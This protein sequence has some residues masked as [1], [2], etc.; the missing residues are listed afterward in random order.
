M[1]RFWQISLPLCS[2]GSALSPLWALGHGGSAARG[3]CPQVLP[4]P[5][6]ETDP[7]QPFLLCS[8]EPKYLLPPMPECWVGRDEAG[9]KAS[10]APLS[11][12]RQVQIFMCLVSADPQGRAG[13]LLQA[14]AGASREEGLGKRSKEQHGR[15]GGRA[16]RG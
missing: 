11:W 4:L 1:F 13:A 9:R 12:L 7:F 16:V 15:L 5:W 10:L 2:V 3:K 14:R 6:E 8:A